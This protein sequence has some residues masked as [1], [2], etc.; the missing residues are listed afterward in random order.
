M[1][2]YKENQITIEN[3]DYDLNSL[4][5][6]Q[7]SFDQLKMVIVALAKGQNK[8][9][10]RVSYIENNLNITDKDGLSE[11]N[12]IRKSS[13][14]EFNF[15][16]ESGNKLLSKSINKKN[17]NYNN[18]NNYNNSNLFNSENNDNN[19]DKSN[20]R[21]YQNEKLD[22]KNNSVI[23][24]NGDKIPFDMLVVSWLYIIENKLNS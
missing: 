19:L 18:H 13:E 23:D 22:E 14:E 24:L 8:L 21:S 20:N 16:S 12:S 15:N 10:D 9:L 7:A 6:I 3:F 4:F 1:T 2:T 5:N 17:K 11:K